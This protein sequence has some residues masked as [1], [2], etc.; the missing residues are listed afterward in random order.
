MEMYLI[1]FHQSMSINITYYKLE[2]ETGDLNVAFG[3]HH[4]C[5]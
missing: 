1:V 2:V 4:G 5:H 3:I